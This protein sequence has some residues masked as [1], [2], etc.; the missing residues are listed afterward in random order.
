[1]NC[2]VGEA[3]ELISYSDPPFGLGT[4]NLCCIMSYG[5]MRLQIL[6]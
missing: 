1:M 2:D 3:M 6:E 5:G 4:D